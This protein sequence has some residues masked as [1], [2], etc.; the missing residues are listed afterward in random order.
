MGPG[1][2]RAQGPWSR[3]LKV[4]KGRS[5]TQQV[6]GRAGHCVGIEGRKDP[7]FPRPHVEASEPEV[8]LLSFHQHWIIHIQL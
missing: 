2:A 1:Q 8:V 7:T 6:F 5:L 3:I 4:S